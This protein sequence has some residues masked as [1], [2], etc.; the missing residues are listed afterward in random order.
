MVYSLLLIMEVV[1]YSA[2]DKLPSLSA[3]VYEAIEE[4][5]YRIIIIF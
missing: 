4:R 3:R 2:S 1:M 5:G